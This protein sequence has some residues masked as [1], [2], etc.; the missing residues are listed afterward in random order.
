MTRVHISEAQ[1]AKLADAFVSMVNRCYEQKAAEFGEALNFFLGLSMS[2]KRAFQWRELDA[3]I[4][5]PGYKTKSFSYKYVTEVL[6]AK[7]RDKWPAELKQLALKYFREETEQNGDALGSDLW[8]T[9]RAKRQQL[10]NRIHT[11]ILESHQEANYPKKALVD[12]LRHYMN[13]S[14]L[15]MSQMSMQYTPSVKTEEASF[16]SI[17]VLFEDL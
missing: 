12:M 11:R 5:H 9:T 3:A 17:S 15:N 8:G 6:S 10:I 7:Q 4:G 14:E 2:D 16:G 1:A 13:R